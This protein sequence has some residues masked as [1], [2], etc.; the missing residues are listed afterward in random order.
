MGVLTDQWAGQEL[1]TIGQQDGQA[2]QLRV[3]C[4]K[5]DML[6]VSRHEKLCP[7]DVSHAGEASSNHPQRSSLVIGGVGRLH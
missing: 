4:G 5:K 1:G 3:L 6:A 7:G 2:N